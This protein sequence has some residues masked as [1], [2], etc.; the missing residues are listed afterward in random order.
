MSDA[1]RVALIQLELADG[2]P[3]RN[4]ARATALIRGAAPADLYLLPELWSTGYA[5]AMWARSAECDTPRVIAALAR[6]ATERQGA[7]AGSLI[8]HNAAGA[9]VNRLWLTGPDGPIATYDKGHL[10]PPMREPE[11]L[12]AGSERGQAALGGWPAALSICFDLRFPEQYRLD[13]LDGAELFVVA[14]EWPAERAETL[15]TLARARAIENQAYLALCNRTGVAADGTRFAGG[16][17][18]VAP[19]GSVVADLGEGEAVAI[20]QLDRSRVAAARSA[21]L[22]ALRRRGLDY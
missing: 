20:V 13:A 14:S 4:L 18:I 2:D 1:L 16:S 10:F 19:D 15:R 12:A 21:P 22:L 8:S 11:L 9:L 17:C 6:L 7:I 3:D 5:H